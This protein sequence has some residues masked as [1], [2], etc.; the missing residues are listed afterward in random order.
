MEVSLIEQ[1]MHINPTAA[2]TVTVI[3][4]STVAQRLAFVASEFYFNLQLVDI[5]CFSVPL[6]TGVMQLKHTIFTI[7]PKRENY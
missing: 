7:L 3:H 5:V 6:R 4:H 2:A 1:I